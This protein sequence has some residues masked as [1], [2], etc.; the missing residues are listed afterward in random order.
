MKRI[1]K[2]MVFV[3]LALGL[4]ACD[5]NGKKLTVEDMREA[6]ASLFNADNTMNR[7]EAPKVAKLY[8]Q[9][10]KQNPGDTAVVKWLYHA[11]EINVMMNDADKS[12][13]LCDQLLEQYPQ[14]KW[15]PMSLL[16]VGSFVYEDM[17]NDTAQAHAA[18]QKLIDNY[19]ESVL[20]DDAQKSIEYLG[21]S[22]EERMS[23][24]MMSQMDEDEEV[25][26]E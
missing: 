14:S 4:F 6:Q 18:Y 26:W 15:A 1:L 3:M 22:Q 25:H 21:L 2:M 9:Y 24:I 13:E 19:P 11:M 20:V 7:N 23:R 12:I 10:V 8:C 17:L 5:G 16:L